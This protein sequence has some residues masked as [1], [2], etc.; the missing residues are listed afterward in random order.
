[1]CA[2]RVFKYV[3]RG[4]VVVCVIHLCVFSVSG[5]CVNC[6]CMVNVFVIDMMSLYV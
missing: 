3:C 2:L 1:M 6:I 5:L 4:C